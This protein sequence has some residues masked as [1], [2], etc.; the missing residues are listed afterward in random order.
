MTAESSPHHDDRFHVAVC[1]ARETLLLVNASYAER[2]GLRPEQIAGRHVRDVVGS[3]AYATLKP[4]LDRVLDGEEVEFVERIPYGTVG[5]RVMHVMYLPE[6][7]DGGDVVGFIAIL[8]DAS[9]RAEAE[10]ARQ[11]A[12][13]AARA[14]Q[15][16]AET[17]NRMK[18]EFLATISHELRTPINAVLGWIR[19][20]D[21]T[22]VPPDVRARGITAIERNVR[23]TA[24][25]IEDLLDVSRTVTGDLRIGRADV[26]V[27]E[28]LR[29]AI[30]SVG[31]AALTKEQR[32]SLSIGDDAPHMVVGDAMRLQ[33]VVWNILTNAIRYTPNGGRIAVSVHAH[34]D[35]VAVQIGDTGEG[36]TAAVLPF[37]FDRFRQGDSS[38]TRHHGG[39]GLG[40]AIA[41]HLLVLHGGSISAH[42]EGRGKGSLF[43]I[44]LPRKSDRQPEQ[45]TLR[46]AQANAIIERAGVDVSGMAVLLVDSDAESREFVATTLRGHHV[47][48]TTAETAATAREACAERRRFDVLLCATVLEDG[49][50]YSLLEALRAQGHCLPPSTAAV[51]LT[52][53]RRVDDRTRAYT[54][55]FQLTLKL[56]VDPSELV[57]AIGALRPRRR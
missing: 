43:V 47:T 42:S 55:G 54:A 29:R 3:G 34:D 14:A 11:I 30:E 12:L 18:D 44:Q 52:S 31:P 45:L 9:A 15:Q 13:S 25:I 6:R 38:T 32:V 26:D 28:L 39:M 1:D 7:R 53:Y 17:A 46:S 41:R 20:L 4:Y 24:T 19:V 35:Q 16:M 40:L 49:D 8:Q 48:V 27:D 23:A 51:A 50:G 5:T 21:G 33:Q 22:G 2:F 56:P 10:Q 36:I 37:I 57:A